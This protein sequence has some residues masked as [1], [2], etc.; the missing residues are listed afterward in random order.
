MVGP[1]L[2]ALAIASL[3]LAMASALWLTID[4]FRHPQ[5]MWIM[6]IVWP[7]TAFYFGPLTLWLYYRYGRLSAKD[8]PAAGDEE[9]AKL[10]GTRFARPS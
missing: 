3:A 9:A 8:A 2:H 7:V 10:L 1:A 4:L 5:K 6:N